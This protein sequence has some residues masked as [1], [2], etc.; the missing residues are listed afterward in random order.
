MARA[1]GACAANAGRQGRE[2][3]SRAAC[4][5]ADGGA[6]SLG[7]QVQ[8]SPCSSANCE[9][10]DAFMLSLHYD[11]RCGQAVYGQHGQHLAATH[12]GAGIDDSASS[13]SSNGAG[14][15]LAVRPPAHRS[16]S[17]SSA[18][19]LA[20]TPPSD[21]GSCRG[22]PA[23]AAV[24]P[25][26]RP[27]DADDDSRLSVLASS[28]QTNP[29][30]FPSVQGSGPLPVSEA[31][32]VLPPPPS[33]G[34]AMDQDA[35]PFAHGNAAAEAYLD[36][37]SDLMWDAP[38]AFA[39]ANRARGG[40]RGGQVA[41]GIQRRSRGRPRLETTDHDQADRRR[42]QIREAQRAYRQRK[43][44]RLRD[45]ETTVRMLERL[46]DRMHHEFSQFYETL[47]AESF[48]DAAPAAAQPLHA[49]ADR[50]IALATMA[51]SARQGL[52]DSR[53]SDSEDEMPPAHAVNAAS[54]DYFSGQL[55]VSPAAAYARQRHDLGGELHGA[56]S[57]TLTIHLPASISYDVVAHA[58]PDNAGFPLYAP[59]QPMAHSHPG[60]YDGG[61]SL[62][63]G[64]A[65]SSS[66]ATH[67]MTFGRR[68][69]HASLEAGLRLITMPS[70]PVERYAAAFGFA[71]FFESRQDIAHRL[72]LLL[73]QMQQESLCH[74]RGPFAYPAGAGAPRPTPRSGPVSPVQGSDDEVLSVA[75]QGT[76]TFDGHLNMATG[77]FGPNAE[78][79]RVESLEPRVRRLVPELDREF[80]GADGVET[81][82]GR[83][84][85][86]VPPNATF[87]E[88]EINVA[89]LEDGGS[90]SSPSADMSSTASEQVELALAA[91]GSV[92]GGMATSTAAGRTAPALV[93]QP[94][95]AA[96]DM[97]RM[98][99][100]PGAQSA[101]GP[102][103]GWSR[104][105][106]AID[107]HVLINEMILSS[108]YL[109][110][111]P[112]VRRTDVNRAVKL[113]AVP[114]AGSP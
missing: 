26:L 39:G 95:S 37:H 50:F 30:V 46:T 17:L 10:D 68:F 94:A 15:H 69:Q 113:A 25:R 67:E 97:N 78:A 90:S 101:W 36:R 18:G 112:R 14:F 73:E 61:G 57:S 45:L 64:V 108:I 82:L 93:G 6:D 9:V 28:R 44:Q 12:D 13:D 84:G 88:A 43:E 2:A 11:Q 47:I 1:R 5:V 56:P 105:R 79:R 86:S 114:L 8:P 109:G 99:A 4:R 76:S 87:V 66:Y 96:V 63:T 72:R 31:S 33:F 27:D 75:S 65:S 100:S 107:V 89:D 51:S 49:M 20:S 23:S 71:L 54:N 83:L 24:V 70:P 85:I 80:L 16:P 81:Y 52:F 104:A 40:R 98:A 92:A 22:G 42:K 48:L 34:S 91:G 60:R 110:T 103:T 53:S 29:A 77:S 41:R 7:R 32:T 19:D 59:M 3:S 102:C 58:T 38:Q 21:D 62:P 74:W 106:V 35:A 55:P 111:T